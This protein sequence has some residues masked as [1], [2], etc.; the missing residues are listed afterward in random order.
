MTEL[1]YGELETDLRG[2]VRGMLADRSPLAGVLARLERGAA[3]D[4]TVWRTLATEMGL[5]GIAVP[6]KFGGGGA[7]LREAAVVLEE[8]GRAVTP[9]PFLSSAVVATSALLKA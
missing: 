5:A 1:L 7:S 2:S 9:A 6:E 3:Y 4:A 8:L